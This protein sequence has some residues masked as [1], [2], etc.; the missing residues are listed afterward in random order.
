MSSLIALWL[1]KMLDTISIFLNLQRLDLWPKMWS[2]PENVPCALEK[3]VY[4][5]AF[6]QSVLKISMR[7]ILS[8]VSF[9]TCVSLLIFCF[10]YLSLDMSGML[11]FPILIVLLSILLFMS[12]CVCLM[13]WGCSYVGFIDIFNCCVFL[14]DWSLDHYVVSFLISYN[15]LYFKAY[16]VWYEDSYSSFLLLPICMGYIFPSS[17]F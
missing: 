12:V 7:S 10:N 6:G 17:H 9:K 5:S 15:L 14:L 2:I 11:K 13:Y 1:E 16:F 3:K 8:N 4:S